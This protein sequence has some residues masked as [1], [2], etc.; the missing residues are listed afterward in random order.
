MDVPAAL[1]AVVA[2]PAG[3]S[4][5]AAL[6]GRLLSKRSPR[7]RHAAVSLGVGVAVF[8]GLSALGVRPS[9][10]LAPSEDGWTWIA[11][12]ALF[13]GVV[14]AA[15]S[16]ARTSGAAAALLRFPLRF[17]LGALAAWLVLSP[18][19]PHS[20]P[21]KTA[22]VRAVATGALAATLS[23]AASGAAEAGARLALAGPLVLSLSAT[24]F[25]LFRFGASVVMAAASGVVAVSVLSAAAL[26]ARR[27]GAL[28]PPGAGLVASLLLVTILLAAHAYLNHGGTV[29]F[30]WPSAALLLGSALSCA[31]PRPRFALAS[32]AACALGAVACAYA[33]SAAASAASE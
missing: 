21:P 33:L 23:V 16:F 6:L 9:F 10:P 1:L 25:V 14:G 11:W 17:A 15:L 4:A 5:A 26:A 30:P 7:A 31:F 19:V 20:V 22:P 8:V 3:V 27:R 28:L 13:G 18:L 12:V 2:V 32:S 24:S 29:R